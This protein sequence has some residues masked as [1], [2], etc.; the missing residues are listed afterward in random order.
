MDIFGVEVVCELERTLPP[1]FFDGQIH[2]LIHL[3][4]EVS[5]A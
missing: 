3:V 5:L 1:S 2:L 4:C